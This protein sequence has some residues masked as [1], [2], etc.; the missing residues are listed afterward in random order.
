MMNV[1]LVFRCGLE[2]SRAMKWEGVVDLLMSGGSPW[3][4][5]LLF[6]PSSHH[7]DMDLHSYHCA[8]HTKINR[9][10]IRKKCSYHLYHS[11]INRMVETLLLV[12]A[13]GCFITFRNDF[14]FLPPHP[15]N[16]SVSLKPALC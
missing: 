6:L 9:I 5:L 13:S 10:I 15:F 12:C 2:V 14:K 8:K 16:I 3:T 4:I 11:S 7:T 1:G